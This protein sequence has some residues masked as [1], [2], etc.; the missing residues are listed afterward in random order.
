MQSTI[1]HVLTNT[2]FRFQTMDCLAAGSRFMRCS[3][4]TPAWVALG[5]GARYLVDLHIVE[6]PES[7]DPDESLGFLDIYRGTYGR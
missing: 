6:W 7:S 5:T 1:D 2:R 4:R 3:R